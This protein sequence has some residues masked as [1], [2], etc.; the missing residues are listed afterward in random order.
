[1]PPAVYVS[2]VLAWQMTEFLTHAFQIF[3]KRYFLITKE[4]VK[5]KT[6]FRQEFQSFLLRGLIKM[7]RMETSNLLVG[8]SWRGRS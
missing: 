4:K 6:L 2:G 7:E 8:Q 5:A 3:F 1:M